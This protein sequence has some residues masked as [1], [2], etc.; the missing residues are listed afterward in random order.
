MLLNKLSIIVRHSRTFSIRKLQE[1]DIGFAEQVVLMY[2]IE[3]KNVN[4]D[5]IAKHFMIDKGTIAKTISKLEQKEL[6]ERHENPSNKR[7]NLLSISKK[8]EAITGD[9]NKILEEWYEYLFDGLSKDDIERVEKVTEIMA[10]N[11]AKVI[12]KDGGDLSGES[13]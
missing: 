2:L 13:K 10:A 3:H 1:Y 4:Q 11:A 12:D 5:S 8:G 9:M 6:I 7:E